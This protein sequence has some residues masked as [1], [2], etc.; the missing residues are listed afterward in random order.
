MHVPSILSEK[1]INEKSIIVIFFWIIIEESETTLRTMSSLQDRANAIHR[2]NI[3]STV[4]LHVN[5]IQWADP[6]LPLYVRRQLLTD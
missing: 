4:Q 2:P 5:P 1:I 3:G 6:L